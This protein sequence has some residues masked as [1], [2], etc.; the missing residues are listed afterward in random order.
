MKEKLSEKIFA[1]V[2]SDIISG[3][4]T[5]RDFISESEIAATYQVSKAPVK[6]ALH[7]LADQGYLVSYPRKGY[8]INSYSQEEIN[9]IQQVRRS[10]ELLCIE[11]VIQNATDAE[12]ESLRT[13]ISGD[14]MSQKPEETINYRFHMGLARISGNKVLAE[15][16]DKLVNIASM[17]QIRRTPDIS[18]FTHI[19]EAA[20]KRDVEEAKYWIQTDISDI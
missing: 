19:I 13:A 12:I 4:Y 20:L 18:N 10:L 17:T 6:E 8:M 15:V 3:K 16:L 7:L 14:D 9:Q 2:R 1:Q 11:L 5:A